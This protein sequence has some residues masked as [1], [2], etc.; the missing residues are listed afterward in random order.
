MTGSLK[1][2]VIVPTAPVRGSGATSRTS[3]VGA[4][5]STTK[6]SPASPARGLPTA[7]TI[8]EPAAV[9]AQDVG[10]LRGR[11]ARQVA[12]DPGAAVAGGERLDAGQQV[13]AAVALRARSARSKPGDRLAEDDGDRA[14]GA[15]AGVGRHVE[16]VGRRRRGVDDEGVAGIGGQGVAGRVGDPRAGRRQGQDVGARGGRQ[17]RQV[18]QGP[19]DVVGGGQRLGGRSA[20]WRRRRASGSGRPGRS[21]RPA[22]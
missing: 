10:A 4:V 20:G 16:D 18:A 11:Q 17:A 1:T 8:P 12:Q 14:D 5:V 21:R 22:R 7:S 6:A 3:A 13:G 15:G 9:R 19:G 2:M